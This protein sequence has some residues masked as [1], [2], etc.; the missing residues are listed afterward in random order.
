MRSRIYTSTREATVGQG[1]QT[2]LRKRSLVL[3]QLD[4]GS[5]EQMYELSC[6]SLKY[7]ELKNSDSSPK[8]TQ[9]RSGNSLN[10][11]VNFA[12]K[13]ARAAARQLVEDNDE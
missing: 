6:N 12:L 4:S 8:P 1:Q 7:F 5:L 11:K 10:F 13:V 9:P 2:K 3:V